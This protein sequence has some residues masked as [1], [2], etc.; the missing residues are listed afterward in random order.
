MWSFARS[1]L[2]AYRSSFVGSFLIVLSAAALLAANGVLME[3]GLR[4]GAPLLATVAASFAGTAILVVVLVV[5][6]TFAS[7]LRQRTAQ[8]ALLRAVGATAGQI[9]SMV[10][11]EVVLVFA[12]AAPLGA[13]PGLFAANL[14]T[15]VLL[16]GGIVPAGLPLA[17]SPLPV[18]AALVVL[19][20][21]ALLAARLAA[22]KVTR[23]S[24]TAAVRATGAESASLSPARRITALV[25]LLGGILVAGTP[26]VVPGTIGS[27]TGA[28]SAFL[29]ISAAALAGPAIV[30]GIARRAVRATRSSS[31]AT[32]MLA[33]VNTRGFSRR[34]TAAII[35]LALLLA[36]GTVQTGVNRSM[37]DAAGMQLREGLAS[38]VILTSPGGVSPKQSAAVASTAGVEAV[39]GSSTVTAEVKADDDEDL[40]GLSWE[41]T[42]I[43]TVSG[44][45]AGLLDADVT[46]GS[47]E[48]LS[49]PATIAASSESLFG[50]GKGV[51]DTVLVR[52][53]GGHRLPAR[54]VA[55]YERGLGFGE[56]IVDEAF[57]PADARPDVDAVLFA[58]GSA[59]LSGLGVRSMS[60]ND[61]VDKT[62]AGAASQQQLSAILLFVLIFFI[63][64]AAANTLVMLTGGRK[65]E[66]AL[67]R[68]IGTTRRQLSSMMA[69]ESVFV[70]VTALVI[71]TLAVIPALV[72][73]AYGMLGRFSL[74]IDWPVYG[75][76]GGAV[77]LIAAVAMAIPARLASRSTA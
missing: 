48:D 36:L 39:V 42:G 37:V 34:L 27:A 55:T 12:I 75:T 57:L 10:T 15:P 29:L 52:F 9:R 62:V 16:A 21:T 64:I 60:V 4:G 51:G 28:T 45:T 23:V 13:I 49:A 14:L 1:A 72:S 56:Y 47:L 38:D 58:R 66:F 7:A 63:A 24:P 32:R 50:T 20:P 5:A 53:A 74:A 25:L 8:F 33:L 18:V 6:S 69:I 35:P 71:G 70:M 2:R 65:A 19:F 73:V 26:F 31:S 61:Y 54:I 77:A 40:G 22:R 67:L 3:T 17:I 44:S 46:A 76:L 30:G 43:R 41:Q 59:D 68:R 11:A